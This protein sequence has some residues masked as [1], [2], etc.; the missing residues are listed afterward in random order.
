MYCPLSCSFTNKEYNI[1]RESEKNLTKHLKTPFSS[2]ERV[3]HV[4]K[5]TRY[6]KCKG[7][8]YKGT[9]SVL[10]YIHEIT[11]I[12][13][14]YGGI[15]NTRKEDVNKVIKLRVLI[16]IQYKSNKCASKNQGIIKNNFL[17]ITAMY[18]HG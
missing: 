7:L 18:V 3:T 17:P 13:S 11:Y 10:F 8:S 5:V 2:Y 14:W 15:N 9:N 4:N 12:S 16:L 6:W 1:K